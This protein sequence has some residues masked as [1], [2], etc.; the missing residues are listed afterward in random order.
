MRQA[1]HTGIGTDDPRHAGLGGTG[2]VYGSGLA[3]NLRTLL[4]AHMKTLMAALAGYD[5]LFSYVYDHHR[6]AYLRLN[7]VTVD[8][9]TVEAEETIGGQV[10]T[11]VVPIIITASIRVHLAYSGGYLDS[12]DSTRLLQSIDNYLHANYDLTDD[13]WLVSTGPTIC[14][15]EFAE[16]ATLGGELIAKVRIL[17]EYTQS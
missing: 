10:G 6:V 2:K 15:A 11:S 1:R 14:R 9:D 16:S 17:K 7:G 4:V 13:F 5:P 8:I 12:R 3:D